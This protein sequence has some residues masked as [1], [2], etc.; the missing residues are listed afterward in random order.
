M[1]LSAF[2]ADRLRGYGLLGIQ[3]DRDIGA[4]E[5]SYR[6]VNLDA[7]PEPESILVTSDGRASNAYVFDRQPGAWWIVGEFGYSW[8]WS[9]EQAERFI[10][11]QP[12]VSD[13]MDILIRDEAGGT[14]VRETDL[15]IYRLLHGRLYRTFQATEAHSHDT[16]DTNIYVDE[17]A[18]IEVEHEQGSPVLIVRRRTD[19]TP[20]NPPDAKATTKRT[21]AVWRWN[22]AQYRFVTDTSASA[23]TLCASQSL[24]RSRLH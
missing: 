12:L 23:R 20:K 13:G 5:V 8:H 3:L 15:S 9:E 6:S 17:R 18:E 19:T 7:D 11:L 14:N 24:T 2:P 4:P 21:C 10:A 16:F 22:P 1:L